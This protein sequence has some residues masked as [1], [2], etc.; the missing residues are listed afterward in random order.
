MSNVVSQ[1]REFYTQGYNI[2]RNAVDPDAVKVALRWINYRLGEEG[3]IPGGSYPP[4][5]R[6]NAYD[7]KRC[8]DQPIVDLAA[9]SSLYDW[10]ET[11]IGRYQPISSGQIALGFPTEGDP[12]VEIRGHLDGMAPPE[13]QRDSST[14]RKCRHARRA[15][16]R[17]GDALERGNEA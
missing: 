7:I 12:P 14:F 10:A 5:L 15:C 9:R 3:M 11:M 13:N 6:N 4:T 17:R 16:R 1:K 8:D 2:L